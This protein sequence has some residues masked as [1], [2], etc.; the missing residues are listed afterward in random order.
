MN[1]IGDFNE[2]MSDKKLFYK[3]IYTSLSEA[4][5]ILKERQK[6]KKLIEKIEKLLNGNIPEPLKKLGNHGVHFRQIATPNHDSRWFIEL[7]KDHGLET[8]FFEYHDDIFTANNDFK[9]SLAQLRLHKEKNSKNGSNLEEKI[10]IVDFNKF[11][12]KKFKNI[13]TLWAEPLV[14]FHNNLFEVCGYSKGEFCFYDASKWFK[15]N[16]GKAVDYYTNMILIFMC[17]GILFENFLLKGS[18][19]EFTKNI[20]LPAFNKAVLLSGVKPLIVPIPPMDNE[21]DSHWISYNIKI[22]PYL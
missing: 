9:Y 20:F 4:K 8:N 3:T 19:G 10:T 22:K 18:E 1:K 5:E 17:H 15:E 11:N 21:E 12:G 7:T 6:D 14:D 13:K 16:G 2:I